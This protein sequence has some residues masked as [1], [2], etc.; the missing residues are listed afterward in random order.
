[1]K[2]FIANARWAP[3]PGYALTS[4]EQKIK[5]A[6]CG[7]RVWKDPVFSIETIPLPDIGDH[8]VLVKTKSCGICGSDSH[9]YETDNNGYIIFSGPVRLPCVIGHEYA[10][11]VEK[12]GRKVRDLSI[13]DP[14][15]GESIIWCG[16]CTPCRS[17]SPNQ[18]SHAELAGI[19]VNGALAE[20][21]VVH[22]RQLWKIEQISSVAD[23]ATLF[24]FG[25]LIEPVGC[26]YNG[27]FISGGG[28]L[29]GSSVV[30]YG[31]G[32]IGLGAVALAYLAGASRI[33]VFDRIDARLEIAKKLGASHTWNLDELQ[34]AAIS[35]RHLVLDNTDGHG[36]NIQVEAAGAAHE[37]IPEMEASLAVNGTI[38]Y[39]G[40]T[41]RAATLTLDGMVTGANGIVGARGHSGYG[42]FPNII[43]LIASGRLK[44]NAMITSTLPFSRT[45]EALQQSTS[46]QDGKI[47]VHL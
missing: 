42:I 39:L 14:V 38:I 30:V 10:G 26:A 22:E 12:I 21:T 31:A 27:L 9:L 8:E 13:G 34:A 15:T 32:P 20:Y 43:Q 40:R 4:D 7:N 47:I 24:D 16:Q 18:C 33:F 6:V 28:F 37:T 11:T 25:A 5:R 17:G 36:A 2:A 23:D 41:G 19:T 29:P 1:M 45:L 46:R 3:Q 44:I 35:P